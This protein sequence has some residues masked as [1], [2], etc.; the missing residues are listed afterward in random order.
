[1]L[2]SHPK[3]V[4]RR[5]HQVKETSAFFFVGHLCKYF[6]DVQKV[7]DGGETSNRIPC[8]EQHMLG[9]FSQKHA[10]GHSMINEWLLF[11]RFLEHEGVT[12]CP[13]HRISHLIH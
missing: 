10:S 1:M 2:L 11:F 5:R 12:P 7:L 4:Q 13:F 3:H 6:V 8:C 9:I